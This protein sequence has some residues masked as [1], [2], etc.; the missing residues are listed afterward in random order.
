MKDSILILLKKGKKATTEIASLI[1]R[2]YYDTL[3]AL[4]DLKAEG[5]IEEIKKGEYTFWELIE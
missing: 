2:N 4:N 3:E 1:K 5:K